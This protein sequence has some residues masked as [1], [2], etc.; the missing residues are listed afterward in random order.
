LA[1]KKADLQ[2]EVYAG[3]MNC[4]GIVHRNS[5]LVVGCADGKL[6]MF[7]WKQFGYHSAEFPGHPDAINALIAV[8]DNVVI[9]AC[10]DGAIR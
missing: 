8:T 10:E 2:S 1:G 3:D 6:Y 5:K 9:T 4:M 7:Q